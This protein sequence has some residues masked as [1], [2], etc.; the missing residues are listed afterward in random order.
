MEGLGR[1]ME[2]KARQKRA[3]RT[4]QEERRKDGLCNSQQVKVTNIGESMKSVKSVEQGCAGHR[5]HENDVA[6]VKVQ[7]NQSL[8]CDIIIGNSVEP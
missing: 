8:R 7:H 1:G 4:G 5:S 2:G 6:W 3:R